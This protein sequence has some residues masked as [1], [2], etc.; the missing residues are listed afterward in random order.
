MGNRITQVFV[1][2]ILVYC[3]WLFYKDFYYSLDTIKSCRLGSDLSVTD[4]RES[5]RTK[6]QRSASEVRCMHVEI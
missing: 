1:N 2:L 5:Y 6:F 3:T 4:G